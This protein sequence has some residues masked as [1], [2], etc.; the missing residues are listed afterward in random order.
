MTNAMWA[1]SFH[2]AAIVSPVLR[3][4]SHVMVGFVMNR[5]R[6]PKATV[7]IVNSSDYFS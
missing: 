6:L 1:D 4:R 5:T 3:K 2:D 7:Y